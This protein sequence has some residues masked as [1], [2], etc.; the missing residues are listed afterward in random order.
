MD[1]NHRPPTLRTCCLHFLSYS[2]HSR[3]RPA[4]PPVV[5]LMTRVLVP[6]YGPSLLWRSSDPTTWLQDD[7]RCL[8]GYIARVGKALCRHTGAGGSNPFCSTR[9]SAAFVETAGNTPLEKHSPSSQ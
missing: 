2:P 5:E 9:Q 7:L 8:H 3:A 1:L 6:P 4:V